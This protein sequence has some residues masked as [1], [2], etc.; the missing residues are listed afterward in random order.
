MNANSLWRE[1]LLHFLVI[2]V[3]LFMVYG[4]VAGPAGPD[5]DEIVVDQ[6]R[7]ASLVENFENTWRRVPTDAELQSLIDAWVREEIL[8]REGVDAGFDQND[9]VIRRRVAQK[10]S[11]IADG[12]VPDA[13]SDAELEAWLRDNIADYRVPA[14]YTLRQVYIDPQRHPDDL[15]NFIAATRAALLDGDNPET[16]G[17]SSML[18]AAVDGASSR[19]VARIFGSVFVDGLANAEIGAWVGPLQS[20]YGLHFVF[21]DERVAERDPA[22]DEVRTAVERDLLSARAE[23]LSETFYASLRERYTVRIDTPGAN[24]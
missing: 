4:L 20:G 12:V 24:E 18:L 1:P 5:K 10:M 15:D 6:A 22:L 2:G 13:P 9:P 17:D 21:V 8:Y 19:D 14:A 23:Q 7:I 16:L 11:F 3:L